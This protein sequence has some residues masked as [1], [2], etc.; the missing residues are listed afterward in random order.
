VIGERI[1]LDKQGWRLLLKICLSFSHLLAASVLLLVLCVLPL[2]SQ[3]PQPP[4]NPL[5]GG[6]K[7]LSLER[8]D[9]NGQWHKAACEGQ[10]LFTAE[11][12]IAVQV[13]QLQPEHGQGDA[14]SAGGYEASWGSYT[15]DTQKQQFL[16]HVEGAIVAP[17][18]GRDLLRS[19]AISG[20]RMTVQAAG[21]MESWRVTWERY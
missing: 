17:L 13:R 14:Y 1:N 6:W 3:T 2:T 7:L 16:F 5:V 8:M 10:F 12:Q 21:A 19:Y 18:I 4:P 11:G 9:A 20:N 15:V